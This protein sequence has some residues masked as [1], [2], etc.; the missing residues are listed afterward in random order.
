VNEAEAN[1]RRAAKEHASEYAE[2]LTEERARASTAA[3]AALS[4]FREAAVAVESAT[5]RLEWTERFAEHRPVKL[6]QSNGYV[7]DQ[8][9]Q[10][11]RRLLTPTAEPEEEEEEE[12]VGV[13]GLI[14]AGAGVGAPV[15]TVDPAAVSNPR[16]VSNRG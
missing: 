1:L 2:I 12:T 8:A 9:L 5:I 7:I 15:A 10:P 6:A 14:G 11:L 4:A 13:S 3:E 16:G